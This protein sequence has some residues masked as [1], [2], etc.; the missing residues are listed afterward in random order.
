MTQWDVIPATIMVHNQNS[1]TN[2][3][4]AEDFI[5]I[6]GEHWFFSL[7]IVSIIFNI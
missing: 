3:G 6:K 1:L 2:I 5:D 7:E 4:S